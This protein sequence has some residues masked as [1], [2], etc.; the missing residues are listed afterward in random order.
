MAT[1]KEELLEA[2][3]E[4]IQALVPVNQFDPKTWKKTPLGLFFPITNP[5][6]QKQAIATNLRSVFEPIMAKKGIFMNESRWD[7]Y[8]FGIAVDST[9]NSAI[10]WLSI[11]FGG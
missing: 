3:K 9:A 7:T 1:L 11:V 4:R 2:L 6:V 10:D 5:L 8:F